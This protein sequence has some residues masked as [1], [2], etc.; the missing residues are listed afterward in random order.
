M[1]QDLQKLIEE[2]VSQLTVEFEAKAQ[3]KADKAEKEFNQMQTEE[4]T[5]PEAMLK[6]DVDIEWRGTSIKLDIP[7]IHKEYED[8]SFDVPELH[9][10]LE[11]I[12]FKVPT[13]EW[14][15]EAVGYYIKCHKLKC[16]KEPITTKIPVPGFKDVTIKM[17]IPKIRSKRITIKTYVPAIDMVRTEIKFKYP[18]F[19][20][21]KIEA[22][23]REKEAAATAR[24]IEVEKEF[25]KD[26]ILFQ[27]NLLQEVIEV[28]QDYYKTEIDFAISENQRIM[29]TYIQKTDE[30]KQAIK[31]AKENNAVDVVPKL[32][33]ELSSIIAEA[34]LTNK[35][36]QEQLNKLTS[37]QDLYVR[38]ITEEFS[39]LT[40]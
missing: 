8:I 22:E 21:R 40:V 4:P 24:G 35:R 36:L 20:I 3:A 9:T 37:E 32:E 12:T 29:G 2:K 30:Y 26:A 10:E 15:I 6:I 31:R 33:S 18:K 16:R 11:T 25:E 13:L 14:R 17:D 1:A 28:V 5:A 23:I 38:K 7:K 19:K 39:A 34:E 27:E